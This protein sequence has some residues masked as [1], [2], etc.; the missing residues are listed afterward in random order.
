MKIG[1]SLV[2]VC[3]T[4]SPLNIPRSPAMCLSHVIAI[5]VND[6]RL[7]GHRDLDG[8]RHLLARVSPNLTDF[9][10]LETDDEEPREDSDRPTSHVVASLL[11]LVDDCAE[12]LHKS[13]LF[14]LSAHVLRIPLELLES[15]RA[16]QQL[17]QTYSRL[18]LAHSRAL[19]LNQSGKRLFD[20][21][22]R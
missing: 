4:T 20:T 19:E 5:V 12:A 8:A 16:H 13:Q 9:L 17:V 11:Q 15:Q 10:G 1:P 18:S 6:L 22:F 14:E 21:Y 2:S 3:P 7:R